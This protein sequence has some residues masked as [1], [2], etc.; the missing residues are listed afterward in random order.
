[1]EAGGQAEPRPGAGGLVGDLGRRRGRRGGAQRADG[2]RRL[3]PPS[4]PLRAARREDAEG[5]PALWASGD[6]E[7]AAREG[8]RPRIGGELLLGERVVVRRDVRRPRRRANSQAVRGGEL[9]SGRDRL[10]IRY[11]RGRS[12]LTWTR[13]PLRILNERQY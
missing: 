7:D 4:A 9:E 3:P 13:Y 8:R 11:R 6:R 10:T 5:D 2:G 12:D 1:G